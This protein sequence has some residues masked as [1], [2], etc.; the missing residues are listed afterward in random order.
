V[1]TN[2][3][4]KIWLTLSFSQNQICGLAVCL[5]YFCWSFLRFQKQSPIKEKA[6]SARIFVDYLPAPIGTRSLLLYL[7]PCIDSR[8]AAAGGKTCSCRCITRFL[9]CFFFRSNSCL[10]ACKMHRKNPISVASC[11]SSPLSVLQSQ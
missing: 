1:Q 11:P 3:P 10:R 7:I 6:V 4:N 8:D 5:L 2:N 9:P